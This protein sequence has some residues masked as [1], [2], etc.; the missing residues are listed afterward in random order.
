[1]T[2]VT[3]TTDFGPSDPFVAIMKGVILG[4]APAATIV[5]V[6]HGIP[7]QDVLAGA[8]VAAPRTRF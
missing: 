3:L 7:P 5:D 1:M 4:R 8:L 2:L 6:S